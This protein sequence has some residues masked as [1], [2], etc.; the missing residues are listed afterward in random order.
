MEGILKRLANKNVEIVPP[1]NEVIF[2]RIEKINSKNVYHTKIMKDF[3]AFGINKHQKH[4][5]FIS[6]RSLF[7]QEKIKSFHLFSIKNDDEFLGIFY[8]YRK[9]I[10]NIITKYA[11]NGVMKASTFSKIYYI[12]FRFKKGSVFCYLRGLAYLLRKEK[13]HKRYYKSLVNLLLLLEKE[14]Y[15][16]YEK[17]LPEG[18]FIGKWIKKNLK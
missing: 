10:K 1:K 3:F 13:I 6:F 14:V 7:N 17:K 18:G 11:E 16:F 12:E 4:K 9:P 15:E 5:F 8:G 2:I